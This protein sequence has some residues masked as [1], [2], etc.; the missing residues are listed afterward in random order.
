[1]RLGILTG[2]GDCPGL[3][4]AIRAVVRT[5]LDR[6]ITIIGFR[7]GWRGVLDGVA[8][9]LAS[10]DVRGILPRGGTILG[11]SGTQP[12]G[13]DG[14][15]ELVRRTI[16][17]HSL[18]GFVVV[19]GE[20][21]MGTT[22]AMP[23]VPVVGIPKTIDNDIGGTDA[24]IGF[25][26]AAQIATDS[27]DRLYSTAESHHRVMV[28]EVMGRSAGWIGI[29]AG[30][31]GAAD[32]ILIPEHPFDIELVCERV[33]QVHSQRRPFSIVVV[34]E[35]AVP[36]RGTMNPPE[37][38]LDE[39]GWPRLGGIGQLVADE[40]QGRVRT[41]TRVTTLGHVQRG[42]SPV[43]FDRVLATRLGT[44]AVDEAISG[45]WGNL[46]GLSGPDIVTTPLVEVG[47][48]AS[49]VPPERFRIPEILCT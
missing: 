33:R 40:I 29:T 42:G 7:N 37:Y 39:N 14:G 38:E 26:T 3:N 28:C 20:G 30:L 41:E 18:D 5:G 9:E 19:G 15:P 4:A 8:T 1:M 22:A 32:V 48:R 25:W 16:D 6:G 31:A 47:A 17:A 43:A 23:D 24:S 35:G 12:S 44:A 2:G 45:R 36:V 46:V 10:D 21:T 49:L 27:I 13:I 11:T 34:S